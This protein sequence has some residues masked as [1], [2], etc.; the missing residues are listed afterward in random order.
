MSEYLIFSEV[1]PNSKELL[2]H[3]SITTV[4][5]GPC[6]LLN[7][8][9]TELGPKL[10]ERGKAIPALDQK[11]IEIEES[12]A[13]NKFSSPIIVP[14]KRRGLATQI[15]NIP[16]LKLGYAEPERQVVDQRIADRK[17]KTG[18]SSYAPVVHF[19]VGIA[20]YTYNNSIDNGGYWTA[21]SNYF[22][23]DEENR[24]LTSNALTESLLIKARN[25]TKRP[26]VKKWVFCREESD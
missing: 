24:Q 11:I 15:P 3:N 1:C 2:F 8:N 25:Q 21:L 19:N 6:G 14:A 20:H 10:P 7:P 4:W 18:F 22:S 16:N 17:S 12:P 5:C 26:N 23:I 9:F 13:G